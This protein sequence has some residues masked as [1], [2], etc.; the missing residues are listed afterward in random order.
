MVGFAALVAANGAV[1]KTLS[2]AEALAA[3]ALKSCGPGGGR[4]HSHCDAQDVLDLE[5]VAVFRGVWCSHLK[6]WHGRLVPL[7][8]GGD[9]DVRESL[10]GQVLLD[11]HHWEAGRQSSDDGPDGSLI[12]EAEGVEVRSILLEYVRHTPVVGGGG[13][14]NPDGLANLL[15]F[16]EVDVV[17]LEQRKEPY[18]FFLVVKHDRWDS[19]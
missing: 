12:T 2:V 14:F 10:G 11:F 13:W 4:F 6:E 8:H 9:D 16:H 15:R 18:P 17:S 1:A 19:S 7:R 5:K 3:V